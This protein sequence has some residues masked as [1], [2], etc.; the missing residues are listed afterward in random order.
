MQKMWLVL[1]EIVANPNSSPGSKIGFINI[2]TWP[3]SK[4]SASSKIE[5]YLASF[6]WHLVLVDKADVIDEEREFGDE[7]GEMI[8]RTRNNPNA[9]ILGTFHTYKTN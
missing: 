2:T 3:D 8:K 9:I 4:E 5:K 1:A 6:G 7:V